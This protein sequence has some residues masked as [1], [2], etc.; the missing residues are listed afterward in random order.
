MASQFVLSKD[1]QAMSETQL[2]DDQKYAV[3]LLQNN[4]FDYVVIGGIAGSGKSSVL[5]VFVKYMEQCVRQNVNLHCETKCIGNCLG[6][7]YEVTAPTG[8]AAINVDGKTL[9]SFLG[10]YKSVARSNAMAQI[11]RQNGGT[12]D[13]ASDFLLL[14]S[15]GV[16]DNLGLCPQVILVDECYM[17]DGRLVMALLALKEKIPCTR[18]CFLGDPNQILPVKAFQGWGE[19]FRKFI[20]NEWCFFELMTIKRS[21][22]QTLTTVIIALRNAVQNNAPL[23][24]EACRILN[25]QSKTKTHDALLC[26]AEDYITVTYRNDIQINESRQEALKGD[27][28]IFEMEAVNDQSEAYVKDSK[29]KTFLSKHRVQPILRLKVGAQVMATR[30]HNDFRNGMV[31]IVEEVTKNG[32]RVK[33]DYYSFSITVQRIVYRESETIAFTQYPIMLAYAMT[34]YKVQGLTITRP[35]FLSGERMDK[36]MMYVI[37]SRVKKMEQLYFKKEICRKN[38]PSLYK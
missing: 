34:V 30:N 25:A 13:V 15:R 36:R 7:S 20:N 27:T 4:V 16:F 1:Q 9:D 11:I 29:K 32:I 10:G 26:E 33:F 23:E 2:A 5:R 22:C 19:D 3:N 18:L 37:V 35:L 24:A 6:P 28:Y 12:R 17:T 8:I 38:Y 21:T 14:K 31:G